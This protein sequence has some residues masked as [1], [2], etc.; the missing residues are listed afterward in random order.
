[1]CRA[2]APLFKSYSSFISLTIHEVLIIITGLNSRLKRSILPFSLILVS[3]VPAAALLILL[4]VLVLKLIPLPVSLSSLP[5][6]V[7]PVLAW[8]LT[9]SKFCRCVW[10]FLN[11]PNARC[12]A[13][14][15]AR[16][17]KYVNEK[18]MKTLVHLNRKYK[19]LSISTGIGYK[20][21]CWCMKQTIHFWLS[22]ECNL[23][24]PSVLSSWGIAPSDPPVL[25]LLPASSP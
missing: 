15:A 23:I 24:K 10:T 17:W 11:I 7:R 19:M 12:S 22:F 1:M 18:K 9:G 8:L 6:Q 4:S 5:F 14:L 20:N 13:M 16:L 25:I 21:V 3:E 2:R